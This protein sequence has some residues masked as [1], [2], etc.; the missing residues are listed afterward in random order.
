LSGKPF[1]KEAR[2]FELIGEGDPNSPGVIIKLPAHDWLVDH[3]PAPHAGSS[4]E[5]LPTEDELDYAVLRLE[6]GAA[7]RHRG[8]ISIAASDQLPSTDGP[9]MILH[10]P[11]GGPPSL[12]WILMRSMV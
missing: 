9:L 12:L 1:Q 11:L 2:G 7:G 3:S 10:Y 8:F 5:I 4:S 6:R